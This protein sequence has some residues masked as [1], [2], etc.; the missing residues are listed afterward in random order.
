MT[1]EYSLEVK[2]EKGRLDKFVAEQIPDL[3][4][5]RVKELVKDQNILVNGK[6]EKYLIR[7]RR[8]IKSKLIFQ[9]LNR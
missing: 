8:E 7:F 1:K 9:R 5:T 4:R 3:S 6:V 2:N